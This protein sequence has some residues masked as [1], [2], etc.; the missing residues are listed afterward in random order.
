MKKFERF[1]FFA[2]FVLIPSVSLADNY[3]VNL[4][5]VQDYESLRPFFDSCHDLGVL[6]VYRPEIDMALDLEELRYLFEG[7][8]YVK[9]RGCPS[10]L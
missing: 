10:G 7:I 5:V 8:G 2:G 6:E 9:F 4:D 3:A 1:L